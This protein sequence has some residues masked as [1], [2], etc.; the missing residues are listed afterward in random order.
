M[1][2]NCSGLKGDCSDLRGE[3]DGAMRLLLKARDVSEEKT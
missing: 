1:E 2:G 3:I